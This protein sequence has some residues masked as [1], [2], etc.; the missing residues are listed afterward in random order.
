M[1]PISLG[2]AALFTIL[3]YATITNVPTV[4]T[5]VSGGSMGMYPGTAVTGF[6][7]G[8]Y[9]HPIYAGDMDAMIAIGDAQAA[10]TDAQGRA[11]NVTLTGVD[12]GG[13]TLEPGVY[14]FDSAA[15]LVGDLWLDGT[16]TDASERLWIFQIGSALTISTGSSVQF[17]N[18]SGHPDNVTWA[19][20]SSA[21]I[22][23]D[24]YVTGN[25]IADASIS[26]DATTIMDGRLIGLNGAVTLDNN[27]VR[28]PG[29]NLNETEQY[30]VDQKKSSDSSSEETDVI[31]AGAVIGG[32]AVL[33]LVGFA[34]YKFTGKA[35]GAAA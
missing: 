30:S 13:M 17:L 32:V 25:M 22:A 4:G 5:I 16:G 7:P 23:A 33:G 31:I 21:T 11:F 12:L 1:D 9:T 15:S 28:M 29:S 6:P 14:K 3:A 20:G 18:N 27:L 26:M 2:T 8:V 24:C 19:L 10:Y 35:A 34:V